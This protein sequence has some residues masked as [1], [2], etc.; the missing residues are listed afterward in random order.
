MYY[1]VLDINDDF[2]VVNKAPGITVQRDNDQAG[3][4]ECV[5]NDLG[6]ETLYP[7]HRLDKLT[8]GVLL[9]ARTQAA[10]QTLSR[11]FAERRVQKYYLAI[12]DRK[13]KKKQGL[14]KGDME[15]ARRGSWKLL[16]S[17]NNPALTQFFSRS[18]GPGLRLFLLK[19]RT[20]KTHQLRV[21]L[22]SL[23]AP[24]LGDE[25]YS[26]TPADRAYLHAW[27]LSFPWGG[28]Q[29]CFTAQPE[30]GSG[31]ASESFERSIE[32]WKLPSVLD[33]PKFSST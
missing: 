13:P 9:M 17:T 12:S 28:G 18:V 29:C 26:G 25:R 31:F 23:G 8:S 22:K 27:Q 21:A 3:L 7:V 6:L 2:I 5:A 16:T 1:S 19:P 20:G 10:N 30:Q 14:I 32:D 4:L 33:W 15:K 24:I 11:L